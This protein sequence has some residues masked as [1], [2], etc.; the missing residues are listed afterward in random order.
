MI[1]SLIYFEIYLQVCH[2]TVKS[3]LNKKACQVPKLISLT[4]YLPILI[5]FSFQ[6]IFSQLDTLKRKTSP[7]NNFPTIIFPQAQLLYTS[8]SSLFS[9]FLCCLRFHH[10]PANFLDMLSSISFFSSSWVP[11]HLTLLPVISSLLTLPVKT[12]ILGESKCRQ[13]LS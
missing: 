2:L 4:N 8:I 10:I 7:L 3:T 13:P 12:L 9:H 6:D 5:Y 1:V 11:Y